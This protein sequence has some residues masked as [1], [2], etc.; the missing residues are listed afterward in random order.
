M[1]TVRNVQG[2]K[3]QAMVNIAINKEHGNKLKTM[4]I[5]VKKSYDSVEHRYLLACVSKLNLSQWIVTF[6]ESIISQWHIEIKSGVETILEKKIERGILQGV[7]LSPL[8]FV[9]CMD[10][11]S[12]KLNLMYP[13]VEINLKEKDFIT[14]HLLFNDDIKLLAKTE[15]TLKSINE[16]TKKFFATVGLEINQ[17]KSAANCT[18]YESDA[19]IL[20][21]HQGYKYLGIT[22]DASI[23]VKKEIFKS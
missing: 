6:L 21:G 1:G 7:S 4:W 2:A 13:K 20:E 17:R 5:D 11:L 8:L 16:E 12:R 9:L 23:I 22:E 10:L 19:V 14:N 3:E 18:R 15:V